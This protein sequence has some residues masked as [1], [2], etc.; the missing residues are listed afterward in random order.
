M[1]ATPE[2]LEEVKKAIE[3]VDFGEVCITINKIGP[4]YDVITKRIQRVNKDS[5]H[6]G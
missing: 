3:S 6:K 2:M 4:F 1:I 5:Y